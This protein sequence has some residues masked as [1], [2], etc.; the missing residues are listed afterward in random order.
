MT[1]FPVSSAW[2]GGS[3]HLSHKVSCRLSLSLPCGEEEKSGVII[4]L[5]RNVISFFRGF[6]LRLE[7]KVN[8]VMSLSVETCCFLPSHYS[9]RGGSWKSRF[10]SIF[11]TPQLLETIQICLFSDLARFPRFVGTVSLRTS[12]N[13]QA[14]GK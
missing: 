14:I 3:L 7:E 4:L 12:F 1:P 11:I 5:R 13:M 10:P 2:G 6:S 8:F 9:R